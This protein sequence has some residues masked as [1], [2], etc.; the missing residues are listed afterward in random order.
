M[1]PTEKFTKPFQ[2][3]RVISILFAT[4]L[5]SSPLVFTSL[6]QSF[7]SVIFNSSLFTSS[8]VIKLCVTP[9]SSIAIINFLLIK[10]L[11]CIKHFFSTG[12]YLFTLHNIYELDRS[13]KFSHL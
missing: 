5:R 9:V 13:N 3:P 12:L 1:S 4:P 7:L 11:T 10:V 6:N 2:E 8:S